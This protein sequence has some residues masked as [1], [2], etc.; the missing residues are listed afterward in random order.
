MTF[1][2]RT[3]ITPITLALLLMFAVGITALGQDEPL[4]P[5]PKEAKKI[6]KA[7]K[8]AQAKAAKDKG[9]HDPH[10]NRKISNGCGPFWAPSFDRANTRKYTIRDAAGKKLPKIPVKFRL[11]CDLHDAGYSGYHVVDRFKTDGRTE[12]RFATWSRLSLDQKLWDDLVTLCQTALTA[13]PDALQQCSYDA[14]QYYKRVR[15]WGKYSFDCNMDKDGMQ[16]S[17]DCTR[18]RD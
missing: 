15:Q 14:R 11:G 16:R 3:K 8:K 7:L 12:Q 6:E 17:K 18:D 9:P 4:E 10:T 5:S 1:N 2:A 13:H